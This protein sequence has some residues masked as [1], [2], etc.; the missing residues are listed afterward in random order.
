MTESAPRV[1][2]SACPLD[3]P[4][5]CSLEVTVLDGRVVA[6]DASARNP[7]TEGF[8]CGKVRDYARHVYHP[9]RLLRPL[10]R[11]GA[12]GAGAWRELSWDAA[13]DL[14]AERLRE[15]A[16]R[17][18]PE[19]ILPVCYGGSNGF[20]THGATDARLFRR[21]GTS[22]LLH[23]VCAAATTAASTGLYGRI[24]GVAL[25]DVLA[26]R[27][28]VVW[29]ANPAASNIHLV[30]RLRRAR[31]RGARLLV[32]DPLRTPLARQADLH[33]APYP[34][35]DLPLALSWI[36]W[37][38]ESG[39]A[40]ERFLAEHA[41]GADELRA[42]AAPWT[43]AR[44]AEAC[45]LDA[46]ALEAG[47][48]LYADASPALL[49]CGWGLERNRNGGSAVC[50]V[51]ALPAVAG[52]FGVRGG[53]FTLSNGGYWTLGDAA[54][55]PEP[56]TRAVNMNRLGR[57]LCGEL[58][59]DPP[60]RALFVYNANPL[61][62]FPDQERLRRG[63]ARE[64]LF[65][66]VFEQV[67]TDTARV[68]DVVLPATTFL[69]HDELR[70]GYGSTPLQLARAAI[71]PVGEARANYA[72][73]ADLA[74]RLGVA[75]PGD[76]ETPDAIARAVAGEERLARLAREGL[77]QP[78]RRA[79]VQFADVFPATP[80]RRVHLVPAALDAEAEGGLYRFRPDPA[81]GPDALA[82]LSPATSRTVSSSL[83]ELR[84]GIVPLRLW[85]DDARARGI[86]DGDPVRV[87]NALGEVRTR[88]RLDPDLRPGVAVLPKGLWSHN[89]ENGATAN[90]LAP[91]TLTDVAGGACFNDARVRV[92]RVP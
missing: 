28:I 4:D 2:P 10:A 54:R 76:P 33:L 73:F 55:E 51:L 84:A 7:D 70:A 20:L 46:A 25:D 27:L 58:D 91:D 6:L 14:V 59:L 75:R 42:R 13:L 63:F 53:G 79:V 50:A 40:D 24:P 17:D 72:V 60:L 39:R 37:L 45:R 22:R 61:A 48:R 41:S 36:R 56:A 88:A 15:V 69:E 65:T 83:G 52:K 23:T 19:A 57:A 3:C 43:F 80:D 26:A 62:T 12:R 68:A 89:T 34:G 71:A 5:A 1:V 21:L 74:R 78:E 66:V 64:D 47:A 16:R 90:A 81:D 82:L 18:G 87:W 67:M 77:A 31:E 85:P 32:V 30:P 8:L 11:V 86:A 49:R 35:T 38:F 44:A 92:E 29:G 9:T